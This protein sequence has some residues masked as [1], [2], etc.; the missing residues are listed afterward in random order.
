MSSFCVTYRKS[1]S[2]TNSANTFSAASLPSVVWHILGRDSK[3]FLKGLNLI[4]KERKKR[5]TKI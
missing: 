5:E 2:G 1:V 3:S 4:V